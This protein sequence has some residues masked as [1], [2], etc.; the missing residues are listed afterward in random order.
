[1]LVVGNLI[2]NAY[3]AIGDSKGERHVEFFI[4]AEPSGMTISV[5]DTG[6]GMTEEQIEKILSR[7]FTTKGAGHGYGMRRIREIVE[8][9]S[10]YLNIESEVGEGT[11]ITVSISAKSP[12]AAEND[13]DNGAVKY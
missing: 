8:R 10:G 3:E 11:S 4:N 12:K 9:H 5:D 13:V 7:A 6:C 2:E 1:M